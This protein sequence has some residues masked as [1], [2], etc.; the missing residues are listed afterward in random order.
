MINLQ[1]FTI[2][3]SL[4]IA[5]D[6]V[7]GVMLGL[8]SM[9][10]FFD[11]LWV[12]NALDEMQS[13]F[14]HNLEMF[15]ELAEQLLEP[16]QVKGIRRIRQLRDQINEGF[17]AVRAQSDAI[18]FEF[19]PSRQR[20]LQIRDDLRRWQPQ[21]RTLLMVQIT[22]IQYLAQKPLSALPEPIARAG[23]GFEKDM[24]RVMRAMASEGDW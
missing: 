23:V 13:V 18:L 3:T 11:R 4:S 5:R 7:F 12:R 9:W 19:G 8:L 10:L 24:A 2:Q 1:E 15:A 14:A 22:A 20:K 16:D 21:V 6:R 17:T